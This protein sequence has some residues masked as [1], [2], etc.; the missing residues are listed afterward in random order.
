MIIIRVMDTKSL[1]RDFEMTKSTRV[2]Y[3]C[4]EKDLE[5]L[6]GFSWLVKCRN[7]DI[8]FNP[9]LSINS[10]ELSDHF[11]DERNMGH[12][13]KIRSVLQKVARGRWRWMQKRIDLP[14]G[15][16][17]EIGCGTG[18]FLATARDSG[19][20]VNGLEL[21]KSFRDAAMDW[22]DLELDLHELV[23]IDFSEKSFDVIALL[24]VFEHLP[25]PIEFL[26]Q[27]IRL[28]KPGGWLFVIVPNL[29]SWTDSL[30]RH[31][32][33]TLIKKDHFFHYSPKTLAKM[34]ARSDFELVEIVSQEPE[35]HIWTSLYGFFSTSK[36][37]ARYRLEFDLHPHG[38]SIL[39]RIKSN[40]P[41]WIGSLT[42]LFL[43]PVRW[44]LEKTN[45]GHEIYLLCRRPS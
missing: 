10:Q 17:L 38:G 28:I 42:S 5:A 45:R 30:F 26:A 12:R 11:Y 6:Q 24:H 3:L 40:F 16:L 21:S 9:D 31:A 20:N 13:R 43:Y 23:E 34:I 41:Y 1:P 44:R 37:L 4:N 32:S 8:V 2:C 27:A 36:N 14:V 19:W 25:N 35:H 33:P 18:E 15:R 7:C 39:S 22:Y 29:S